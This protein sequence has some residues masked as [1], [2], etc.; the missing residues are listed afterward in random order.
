MAKILLCLSILIGSLQHISA[1]EWRGIVPSRSTREDVSRLL[2]QCSDPN[3]RCAFSLEKEDVYMVFSG[4]VTDYHE[5]AKDLP[6]DTVLLI[7]VTPKTEFRLSDFQIDEKRFSKFDPASPPGLGFAGYLSEEEG[8]V[9]RTYKGKVQ[10]ID[11]FAAAKDKHRC[12]SYYQSPRDF[13]QMNVDFFFK[14]D[15]WG[16]ILF[17]DEKAR[18]D[19]VAS[20]LHQQSTNIV[21]LIIYAGKT[22]CVGEAK[23]RGIRAK[24]YLLSR[25]I[26]PSR[27]VWI[28]GGYQ[29]QVTTEVW[30][31]PRDASKPSIS[32]EFN[33]KPTDLTLEKCKIKRRASNR[34]R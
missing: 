28:D 20:Q 24:K 13:I 9:F 19:N 5:C 14:F 27:I 12:S 4:L 25:Q 10:Q 16:D 26:T 1:K 33:L 11:Y 22:A 29:K 15:E 7:E 34:Y 21:Y 31:L 32:Q 3:V 23:A 6:A 17:S 18:L 8:V 2:G 30:I